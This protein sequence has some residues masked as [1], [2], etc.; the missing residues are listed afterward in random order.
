MLALWGDL[1]K[2]RANLAMRA[3]HVEIRS[4]SWRNERAREREEPSDST[5]ETE[6]HCQLASRAGL[7]YI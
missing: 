4:I 2:C 6:W 3:D 1:V 5:E 7:H